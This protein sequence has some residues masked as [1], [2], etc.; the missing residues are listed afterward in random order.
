MR[1]PR[2]AIVD[3]ANRFLRWADREAVHQFQ[4]PHR[5]IGVVL[6]DRQDRLLVQLR[7]PDKLTHAGHWDISCAG[8][9]EETDYPGG[10][11]EALRRATSA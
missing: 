2:V 8:H 4:A 3:G 9:V 5:S 7:H 10:P 6:F 11:D 1:L